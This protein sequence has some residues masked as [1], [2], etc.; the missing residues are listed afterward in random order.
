MQTTTPSSP[1]FSPRPGVRP[2]VCYEVQK[3]LGVTMDECSNVTSYRVQWAP[4]WVT[5]NHL[6]GCEHLL[7]EFMNKQQKQQK[8][9]Q[10]KQLQQQHNQQQQY[11]PVQN[12]TSIGHDQDPT[13]ATMTTASTMVIDD[14]EEEEEE[15]EGGDTSFSNGDAEYN[16]LG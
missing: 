5:S 15:E 11:K 3:I 14:D 8:Q 6:V 13:T 9:Q 16:S 12:R 2:S 7:H 10:L 4:A 1:P